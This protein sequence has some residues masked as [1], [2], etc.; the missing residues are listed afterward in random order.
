MNIKKSL[1]IGYGSWCGLGFFRGIN[2]Y[3]YNHDKC[4]DDK[5]KKKENY[6]YLN[7]V[8][9]GFFGIMVYANPA[10]MPLSAY[11]EIYRLEVN[12]R[13]LENEKNTDYYNNLFS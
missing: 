5:Y 4:N 1:T 6:L 9:Y 11:K 7:S 10:T 3:K 8:C 13:K 12:L 2:Y